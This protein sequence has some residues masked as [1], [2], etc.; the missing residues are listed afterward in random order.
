MTTRASLSDK[1]PPIWLAVRTIVG[2]GDDPSNPGAT[3]ADW[4]CTDRA[5]LETF[6]LVHEHKYATAHTSHVRCQ[7]V[8]KKRAPKT[9]MVAPITMAATPADFAGG[10]DGG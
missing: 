3:T 10:G 6:G 2:R 7:N 9:H 5:A 8:P 4:Q 1:F